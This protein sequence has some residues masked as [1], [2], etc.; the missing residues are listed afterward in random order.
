[1]QVVGLPCNEIHFTLRAIYF[2]MN[3]ILLDRNSSYSSIQPSPLRNNIKG[4]LNICQLPN[5]CFIW[6]SCG[7]AL[8]RWEKVLLASYIYTW[9]LRILVVKYSVFPPTKF[10]CLSCHTNDF[11]FTFR[12]K[13][14]NPMVIFQSFK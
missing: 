7:C 3:R 8:H 2:F 14:A 13:N 9:H 10:S 5:F 6:K 4:I 1:M 11:S 12:K